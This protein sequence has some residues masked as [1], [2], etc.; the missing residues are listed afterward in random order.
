MI[1]YR[2]DFDGIDWQSPMEG[3]RHKTVTDGGLTLRL[4]EYA[5][6]MPP[7][8]CAKGHVGLIV[9]GVL[10]IEFEDGVRTFKAGDGVVIP[11]GE[12]HRHRA[13]AI[14]ETVTAVFVESA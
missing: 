1:D 8:W 4:V 5:R 3:V 7:H 12:A 13:R 2:V 11:E 14:T 10:E 9:D 6:S